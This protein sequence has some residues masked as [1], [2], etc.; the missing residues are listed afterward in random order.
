MARLAKMK[1][2]N[3]DRNDGEIETC[4]PDFGTHPN[5]KYAHEHSAAKE[6]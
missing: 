2:T 1:W 5:R 3:A 6:A 4:S